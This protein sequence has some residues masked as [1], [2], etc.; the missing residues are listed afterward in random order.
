MLY[1]IPQTSQFDSSQCDDSCTHCMERNRWSE[2]FEIARKST[3]G[4]IPEVTDIV[5]LTRTLLITR[6]VS[7]SLHTLQQN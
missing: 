3:K 4:L 6:K 1:R 5:A 7:T 2:G